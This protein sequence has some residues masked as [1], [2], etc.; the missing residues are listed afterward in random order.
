MKPHGGVTAMG[1]AL[2]FFG[3]IDRDV[4]GPT[5]LEETTDYRAPERSR[6]PCDDRFST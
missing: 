6:P 1:E 5:G 2:Q 3:G 4:D